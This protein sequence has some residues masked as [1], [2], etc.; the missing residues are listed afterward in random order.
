MSADGG[1]KRPGEP[2][3]PVKTGGRPPEAASPPPAPARRNRRFYIM[4]AVPVLLVLVGGYFW[5]TGGRTASTDNSYV[6]QDK[7]TITADVPGRIVKVAVDSNQQVAAG[8]LLLQIDPEP[9]RI[10]LAQADA[11]VATARLSVE[12]L[13]S[14]YQQA[15][16]AQKTSKDDLTFKQKD[17]DRQQDLLNKGVSSQ[18]TYEQVEND[19]HTDQETVA[20]AD[21]QVLAALAALGGDANIKTDDHPTVLAALAHRQ[22]AALDLK[23]TSVVAPVA[24]VVAQTGSLQVGGYVAS[25]A[26]NP[27]ALLSIVEASDTWVEANFK[28]TDLTKMVPGQCAD[29]WIDAY[30]GHKFAGV[31][32]SIGAGTGAEFSL[33]PAQNATGNWVKVVQRVPVRIKIADKLP[34]NVVLRTGLSASV[35]VDFAGKCSS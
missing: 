24:G 18:A 29:V 16:V 22:Q 7:V 12:Q 13:R 4:A 23:N 9:Y 10:A 11:A 15:L 35:T 32:E 20:K 14:A 28:E 6:H 33:L 1:D 21:E 34:D 30:P 19:L 27:T 17:F 8:D 3:I 2:A 5:L 26:A 25:P 31:V